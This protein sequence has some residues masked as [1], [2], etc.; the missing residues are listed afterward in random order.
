MELLIQVLILFIVINSLFKLSFWK[1][2]QAA[3]FGLSCALFIIFTCRYA[4]LQ[5]KTQL[6]DF[7]NT[8]KILQDAAVLITIE[9]AV[10]FLFCF[11]ALRELFG[12][13][14]KPWIKP[15]YWYPSLLVFPALFYVLT[16]LIFLMPGTNF[17]VI[18]YLLAGAMLVLFP[19]L[20][21]GI[22]KL[23][24]EKEMRLEVHFLISLFVC[25]LGLI[26]TVNGNVTYAATENATNWKALLFSLSLFG[27]L[28][29]AG[30]GWNK[31]KWI[32]KQKR[33]K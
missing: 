11:A 30:W 29:V 1:I 21:Y 13:K 33:D 22:R 5:S 20:S 8:P 31:I 23:Y 26:S 7:L 25:L 16:Q 10:C 9:S 6:S 4:V 14:H 15:L 17:S 18:S 27:L 24:P 12:K 32:I 2:G 28:F 3:L 19:A